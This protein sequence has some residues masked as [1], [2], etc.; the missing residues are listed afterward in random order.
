[1]ITKK[2]MRKTI[3]QYEK[4]LCQTISLFLECEIVVYQAFLVELR[5]PKKMDEYIEHSRFSM[6]HPMCNSESILFQDIYRMNVEK[7]EIMIES[8]QKNIKFFQKEIDILNKCAAEANNGN[9]TFFNG[10]KV[11]LTIF[12]PKELIKENILE[13][14]GE[15]ILH[16]FCLGHIKDSYRYCFVYNNHPEVIELNENIID[17]DK[18]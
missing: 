4:L 12:I 7:L 2:M 15:D 13:K 5:D 10:K 11:G 9:L 17:M 1:M 14:Y 8:Y 6:F 16:V 18:V 3:K